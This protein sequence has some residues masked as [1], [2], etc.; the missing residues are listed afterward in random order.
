M[1]GRVLASRGLQD[2]NDRLAPAAQRSFW[3]IG[4]GVFGRATF[5]ISSAQ[6][7]GSGKLVKGRTCPINRMNG[8]GILADDLPHSDTT[9]DDVLQ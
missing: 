2:T 4:L 6:S 5:P 7:E 1:T 3:T 9:D 8:H